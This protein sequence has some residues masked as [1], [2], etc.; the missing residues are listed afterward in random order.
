MSPKVW[1]ASESPSL[2]S[3]MCAVR[4]S[5]AANI[6]HHRAALFLPLPP[7]LCRAGAGQK[8]S[9]IR[10]ISGRHAFCPVRPGAIPSNISGIQYWRHISPTSACKISIRKTNS[11]YH[12]DPY[13]KA[14]TKSHIYPTSTVF[15]VSSWNAH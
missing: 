5:D 14:V 6:R 10:R 9:W 8:H 11:K 4:C 13:N 7:G 15:S 3:P 2:T 1:M 12:S